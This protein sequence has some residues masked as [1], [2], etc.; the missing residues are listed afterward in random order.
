MLALRFNTSALDEM[1]NL[2]GDLDKVFDSNRNSLQRHTAWTPLVEVQET[3]DAVSMAV[4][5]PGVN[6]EDVTLSVQNGL[7]TIAGEKKPANWQGREDGALR[8]SERWYGRFE[9]SF[10]LPAGVEAGK[11]DASYDAGILTIRLHKSEQAKA[12]RI[13]IT[14]GAG[15]QDAQI[16]SGAK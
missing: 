3:D 11:I 15:R 10:S 7:L 8:Y 9:R 5:L 6:A 1:F 16:T 2:A 4:E 13:P 14:A 12:R